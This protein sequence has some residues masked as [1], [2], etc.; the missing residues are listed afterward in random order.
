M[1]GEGEGVSSPWLALSTVS[2]MRVK[3]RDL[4]PKMVKLSGTSAHYHIQRNKRD[5]PGVSLEISQKSY[6]PHSHNHCC[7]QCS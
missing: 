4:S 5:A 7:P 2:E 6:T 3:E 1:V